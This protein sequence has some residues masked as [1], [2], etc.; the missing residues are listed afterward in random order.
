M[1][2]GDLNMH[3]SWH[4]HR[5]Q[6]RER[7]WKAE[8]QALEERKK[9]HQ[10]HK[11]REEERQLQELQRSH[12]ERTGKKRTER[13]DW[14]YT[15]PATTA[16][17]QST[18]A[19]EEYFLWRKSVDEPHSVQDA[20]F[21]APVIGRNANNPQDTAAKIRE[22]PLLAMKKQDQSS[23][24]ALMTN[25]LRLR[26]MQEANETELKKDKVERRREKEERN[27][28][29]EERR[30]RRR[31][32]RSRSPPTGD[33]TR[34]FIGHHHHSRRTDLPHRQR[35]TRSTSPMHVSDLPDHR[36]QVDSGPQ[37]RDSHVP[38]RRRDNPGEIV[39]ERAARLAAMR[40]DASAADESRQRR[41]SSLMTSEKAEQAKQDRKRSKANGVG[42]F[43]SHEARKVYG[44]S[45]GLE[46]RIRRGRGRMVIDRD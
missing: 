32:S 25:P 37:D 27:R 16:A 44:G 6:N 35:R 38:H 8:N 33:S 46:D 23:Y 10:L 26:Q 14:M 15:S 13:I 12:E 3:K 28:R 9:L 34:H 2:G 11:E 24:E 29:K 22:D 39:Q 20:K 31:R 42:G 41:L 7:V 43:M 1:G 45:G 17:V 19:L 4:P 18:S 36:W 21:G 5:Y 40:S 30:S